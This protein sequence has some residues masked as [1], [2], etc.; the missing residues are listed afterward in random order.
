[1][2]IGFIGTGH[3]AES[4]VRGLLGDEHYPDHILLSPRNAERAER[5]ATE[6]GSKVSVAPDNQSVVDASDSVCLAVR[7]QVAEGVISPLA[8]TERH[9]VISFMAMVPLA[10]VQTWVAP[11][12]SVVRAATLPY[13]AHGVGPSILY[14]HHPEVETL[15]ARIG[16]PVATR[17]ERELELL[18]VITAM[19]ASYMNLI[20]EVTGWAA[21]HGVERA[22]A[23]AFT[24]AM[25]RDLTVLCDERP[26]GDFTP[27]VASTQ[28]P[29]GINEQALA[30]IRERGGF[31]P[32]LEAL[33]KVR[34]R[35]GI[36]A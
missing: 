23:G 34:E 22:T 14:P 15:L 10:R 18:W 24:A 27:L 31:E 13:A 9:T 17:D 30:L 35:L 5:L 36:D 29:G 32:F 21:E 11:A 33:E 26:D 2:T 8:F 6:F 3:L 28:T 7:P 12:A 4:V 1:M 19:M 25:F 20:E 16:T